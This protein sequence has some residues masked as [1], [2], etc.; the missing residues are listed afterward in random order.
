MHSRS[1]IR[2]FTSE[3]SGY[4]SYRDFFGSKKRS[5]DNLEGFILCALGNYF[6]LQLLPLL[7]DKELPINA[8][9]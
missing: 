7:N 3:I 6:A 4:I 5:T 9:L 8:G 1:S 2:L